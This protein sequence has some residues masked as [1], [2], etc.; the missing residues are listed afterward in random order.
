MS[1]GDTQE[2]GPFGNQ[3]G[4]QGIESGLR[5]QYLGWLWVDG[6]MVFG[7]VS[8]GK[9]LPFVQENV[10][11][12]RRFKN[13]YNMFYYLLWSK[14]QLWIYILLA[15]EFYVLEFKVNPEVWSNALNYF[16][17]EKQRPSSQD[18]AR[19]KLLQVAG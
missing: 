10:C 14:M 13:K 9:Q 5:H 4:L 16:T 3:D 6:V 11:L 8:N 1:Q 17:K 15:K 12:T 18:V 2:D 19:T 7:E